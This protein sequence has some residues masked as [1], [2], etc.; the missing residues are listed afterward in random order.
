MSS[1]NEAGDRSIRSAFRRRSRAI[2]ERTTA[3]STTSAA[4]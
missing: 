3:S 2:K 4:R 1:A